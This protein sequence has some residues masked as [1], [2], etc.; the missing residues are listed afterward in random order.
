[1][2]G[3]NKTKTYLIKYSPFRPVVRYYVEMY[4]IKTTVSLNTV[5]TRLAIIIIVPI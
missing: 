5:C 2:Y 4:N 1:M 3:M